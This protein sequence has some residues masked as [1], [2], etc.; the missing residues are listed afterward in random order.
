MARDGTRFE[1]HEEASPAVNYHAE[2]KAFARRR[3]LALFLLYGWVPICAGLIWLSRNYLH[4]PVASVTVVGLW[5]ACALGAVW[6]AG[7]YRCPRCRRRYAALGHRKGNSNL[8]RGMFDK[9][10]ANCKLRKFENG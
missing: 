10:C 3:N 8:T 2:W 5:L 1:F 4:A 9:V 7:E 6:W